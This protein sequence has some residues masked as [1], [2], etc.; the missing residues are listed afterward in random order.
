MF[1]MCVLLSPVLR[2]L[3]VLVRHDNGTLHCTTREKLLIVMM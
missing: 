3:G 2:K 1:V